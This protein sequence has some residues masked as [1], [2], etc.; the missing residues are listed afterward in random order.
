MV[1]EE[2]IKQLVDEF[3]DLGSTAPSMTDRHGDRLGRSSLEAYL[4]GNHLLFFQHGHVLNQ[5]AHHAFAIAIGGALILPHT[6]KIV[7]QVGNRL[8]FERGK[9]ALFHFTLP[10]R[11][12][13]NLGEFA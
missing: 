5:Q 4:G 1:P 12:L 2:L 9:L 7:D 8:P 11:F 10:L 3:N 13:L 6:G